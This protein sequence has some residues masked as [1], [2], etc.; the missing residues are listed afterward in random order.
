MTRRTSRK[1]IPEIAMIDDLEKCEK[2][3]LEALLHL[4]DKSRCRIIINS[5]GGSV[6][7]G[8]G[9]ATLIGMKRLDATAVV[10]ADCSSSA[11]LVFAACRHRLVAPHASFLFHPMQWSSEERSRLPGAMGWAHE[12]RRIEDACAHWVCAHLGITRAQYQQWVKRETYITA[13]QM[14]ERGVASYIPEVEGA[15]RSPARASKRPG[16]LRALPGRRSARVLPAARRK[17][18]HS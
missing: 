4:P 6:Y 17:R 12:F 5:G 3:V 11:L 2:D 1:R 15:G 7:A 18:S 9:I 8:L 16:K 13:E 14:V 10:L